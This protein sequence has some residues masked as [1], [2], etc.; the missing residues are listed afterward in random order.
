[1]SCSYGPEPIS[2][3]EDFHIKTTM[4][5]PTP[6]ELG[7]GGFNGSVQE[8]TFIYFILFGYEAVSLQIHS[9]EGGNNL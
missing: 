6:P 3:P 9:R 5:L 2:R 4:A 7:V 8:P 1:M